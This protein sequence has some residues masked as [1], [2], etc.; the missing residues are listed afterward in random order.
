LLQDIDRMI[1]H[2]EKPLV[3]LAEYGHFCLNQGASRRVKVMLSGQGSDELFGGYYYWW[4]RRDLATLRTFPWLWTSERSPDA[5]PSTTTEILD[6]LLAEEVRRDARCTERVET[7]FADAL[8]RADTPDAFNRFSYLFVKFHLHEMLELEDRHS[9]SWSVESRVPFLDHRLVTWVLNLPGALK[10][11]NTEKVFLKKLA[12]T[13]V[14]ELPEAIRLRKK[15]PMPPP[16]AVGDLVREMVSA[17]QAP[18]LALSAYLRPDRLR[19]FLG[20]MA[21]AANGPVGQRHY[22][23][24]RL[25]FLERW[26]RLFLQATR[27]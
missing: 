14:P 16:F 4:Q 8:A 7:K 23:L 12:Q 10:A 13:H 3:T 9:M 5:V 20:T 22:A 2:R 1:W 27:E 15:S 26:H 21:S 17:L 18:N 24:F 11:S 25:Y 19:T 6:D